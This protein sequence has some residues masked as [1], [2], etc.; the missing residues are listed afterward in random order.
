MENVYVEKKMLAL[1]ATVNLLI[2][3]S[4]IS[5]RQYDEILSV[6][7]I[8]LACNLLF[9]YS[10]Y[11]RKSVWIPTLA[12]L[13][14]FLST[15]GLILLGRLSGTTDPQHLMDG[16][17]SPVLVVPN[18]F[19]LFL[20]LL[21]LV[22]F[23]VREHFGRY[24]PHF[25]TFVAIASLVVSVLLS[26][27]LCLLLLVLSMA[28]H[29]RLPHPPMTKILAVCAS[30]PLL[31]AV[32]AVLGNF[33][34]LL[35][36]PTSRI[37]VWDAALHQIAGAPWVGTGMDSFREFYAAHIAGNSYG[38]GILVDT[39]EMPWAHNLFFDI[40]IAFGLP[41]MIALLALVSCAARITQR[42]ED[43]LERLVCAA[44]ALFTVA[45]VFEFTHLRVYPLLV[46]SI[47][48]GLCVKFR[49]S[50]R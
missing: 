18:D 6:L 24:S 23:S 14:P 39:R 42:S 45:A 20:V 44:I 10:L 50:E 2:L 5:R 49:A 35:A 16:L 22:Q 25:L 33:P 28:P 29:V 37:P 4:A 46:L 17:T 38:A 47:L 9:F 8:L 12:T 48:V 3:I 30:F 32:F 13:I 7:L 26:S 21:P 43:S 27:R 34:L 15:C 1:F 36:L 31:L 11:F 19:A 41:T 40:A